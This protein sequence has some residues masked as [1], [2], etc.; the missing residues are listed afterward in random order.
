MK[1]F[2]EV[3]G[4]LD[5]LECAL[6]D[7][8]MHVGGKKHSEF[9]TIKIV[10][11]DLM[12]RIH[13]NLHVVKSIL[14]E[15]ANTRSLS[16]PLSVLIRTCLTDSLTGFYLLTF[17]KDEKSFENELNMMAL[18]YVKYLE[19]LTHL[20]PQ[21]YN[22]DISPEE[23]EEII[24]KKLDEIVE[25][26]PEIVL[27]REKLKLIKKTSAEIRS[28]SNEKIFPSKQKMSEPLSDLSKFERLFDYPD[29]G[30]QSI[31]Y[32]Y[33][34]FRFY[35]QF[36]HYSVSTRDLMNLTITEHMRHLMLSFVL[37]HQALYAFGRAV[38]IPAN[39]LTPIQKNIDA[40][41]EHSLNS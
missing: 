15:I 23:L 34:L 6:N 16:V 22:P 29:E 24:I 41:Y 5:E 9:G 7:I 11:L 21:F 10:I 40:L 17:S 31:S 18:D 25:N 2:S 38:E 1:E 37:I 35:S 30:V 14:P 19:K 33:P 12:K 8:A 27:R 13:A 4:I 28:T 26:Y 32:L 20:E 36:H 39:I 3:T